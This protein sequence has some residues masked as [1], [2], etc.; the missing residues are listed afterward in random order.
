MSNNSV[1]REGGTW[2]KT[3][4]SMASE[5][6]PDRFHKNNIQNPFNPPERSAACLY[7]RDSYYSLHIKFTGE[8]QQHTVGSLDKLDKETVH[9][10]PVTQTRLLEKF[11]KKQGAQTFFSIKIRGRRLFL[12]QNLKIQD[13]TF[14]KSHF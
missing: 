7:Q 1:F 14:Q 5:T 4:L 13:F 11:S 2:I 8:E 10:L 9:E 12:R 6:V 3:L